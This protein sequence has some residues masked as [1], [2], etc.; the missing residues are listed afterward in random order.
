LFHSPS[1]LTIFPYTTLFRSPI[2]NKDQLEKTKKFIEM[3]KESGEMVLEGEVTGNFVTPFIFK[4]IKNDS[5]I[6]QTEL[7][8]PIG[9]VIKANSNDEAIKLANDTDYGLTA[10][11]FTRD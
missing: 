5:E 6:A 1:I 7:F 9:L 3:A 2:I 10:A 11:V 4:D 8:S